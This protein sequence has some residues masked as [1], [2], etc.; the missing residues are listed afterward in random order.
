MWVLCRGMEVKEEVKE[1]VLTRPL[2]A[3]RL[4]G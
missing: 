4:D 2:S 3:I 1:E